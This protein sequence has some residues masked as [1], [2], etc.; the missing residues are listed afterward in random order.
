MQLQG[1]VAVVTG[2]GRGIGRA[3][4]ELFYREGA[5]VAIV[6]R[7]AKNLQTAAMEINRGDHRIV[8]FRCAFNS[9]DEV[10]V[11][12]GNVV[13]VWER[14][15]ILVNNAGV[16]A[17][18]PVATPAEAG[19]G[20]AGDRVADAW[21]AILDTN[22]TGAFTCA[23]EAVPRMTEDG[24]G[25]IINIASI[26]GTKGA[27][28]Y[29]AYCAS[30]HG[31]IGLTRSLA[32]QLAPQRITVNAICPGWGETGMAH[33]GFEAGARRAGITTEGY[34]RPPGKRAPLRRF[35]PAEAAAPLARSRAAGA[36]VG[37]GRRDDRP[38]DPPGWR[39]D[40][41]MSAPPEP[42]DFRV[43][44]PIEVRFRDLDGMGHV[45]NAVYL[46]YLEVARAHY[47]RALGESEWPRLRTYV[48]ARAEIDYRSPAGLGD[49]LV[50]H[51]RVASFGSRSF[52]MEYLLVDRRA[53]RTIAEARTVQAMYDY[54]AGAS[55]PLD[56]KAKES[57]RRFEGRPIP[58]RPSGGG[59]A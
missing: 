23:R 30:K 43:A 56:E 57:I 22:L 21:R 34:R 40:V 49:D 45:N 55:R 24:R 27:A 47:W 8:P 41:A 11:M 31:V 54:E 5:R 36:G 2:G 37:R 33:D 38:G 15:D 58:E 20:T 9:R 50:C 13:E 18:T 14:V 7:N 26:L 39:G 25:R 1:R 48:V 12:I 28:G 3:I 59:R 35:C 19:E 42:R 52:S 6:S 53:G 44:A 17:P 32:L 46:T 51:V 16:N 29:S 10:E 4:A